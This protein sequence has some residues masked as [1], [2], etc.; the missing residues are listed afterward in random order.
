VTNKTERLATWR[1][2][3]YPCPCYTAYSEQLK[4]PS[5]EIQTSSDILTIIMNMYLN[6]ALRHLKLV[7]E[8]LL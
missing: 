8:L 1:Q 2:M 6:P 5:Y 4:L 3:V 7:Q